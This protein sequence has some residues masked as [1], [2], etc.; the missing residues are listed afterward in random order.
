MCKFAIL[1]LN[2]G[3]F[4]DKQ[5]VSQ[6]S[7]Q[8]LHTPFVAMAVPISDPDYGHSAYALGWM[9]TTYKGHEM[10]SHTGGIDGFNAQVTLLPKDK[11]GIVAFANYN[12]SLVP[13]SITSYAIDILLGMEPKDYFAENMKRFEELQAHNEQSAAN[14]S[15]TLGT[16]P[17]HSF[18]EYAG[19]Y[20]HPGYGIF[21]VTYEDE[22]LKAQYNEFE[23]EFEHWNYDVFRSTKK[24]PF[25]HVFV[26]FYYDNYGNIDRVTV[27]LEPLVDDI[28]FTRIV[29]KEQVSI[30]LLRKL[31]GE[32]TLMGQTIIVSIEGDKL[33]A[34]APGQP[35]FEFEPYKGTEF[36]VKGMKGFSVRFIMD[37]QDNAIEMVFIQPNG[38]FSAK[39]I[40]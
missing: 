17:S 7:M 33:I 2:N 3:V 5:I 9:T 27:P 25:Q 37:E 22:R 35:P 20:E 15:R 18:E 24:V 30:D 12:P 16:S 1:H 28:V 23:F 14:E 10:L 19:T 31:T 13:S 6:A 39:R 8:E 21:A 36:K 4:D 32:Y 29:E 38:T 34:N 26:K 11:I 40:K